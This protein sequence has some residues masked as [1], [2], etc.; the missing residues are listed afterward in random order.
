MCSSRKC[1]LGGEPLNNWG[2]RM[3]L[4][5]SKV[6]IRLV[7]ICILL[8]TIP[9]IIVGTYSTYTGSQAIQ[10]KVN[11]GNTRNLVQVQLSVEQLLYTADHIMAQFIETPVVKD[12]LKVD[13]QGENFLI[14]NTVENAINNLPTYSL[15]ASE[16]CFANVEKGWVIDNSGIYKLEDYKDREYLEEFIKKPGASFWIDEISIGI[17]TEGQDSNTGD[18]VCLVKKWPLF[19]TEP[20]CITILKIPSSQFSN[21]ISDNKAL[22]D[23][24]IIGEDGYVIAHTNKEQWGKDYN[25]IN[26]YQMATSQNADSGRFIIEIDKTDYSINYLKSSYNDWIYISKTSIADISKDS[27]TIAWF[28]LI[29]CLTVILLVYVVTLIV[30]SRFYRPIQK[31]YNMV[32]RVQDR[33]EP[34]KRQDEFM[35]I[36][37]RI[38]VL[39][40][41][42]YVLNNKLSIQSRQLKEYFILQ[43]V[44]RDMDKEVVDSRVKLYGFPKL[45]KPVC[46]LVTRIDTFEDT[47]YQNDDMDL[48]LFAIN[49]IV[50]ELLENIIVLKPI[51]VDEYQVTIIRLDVENEESESIKECAF[52]LTEN[53][54]NVINET[55]DISVSV[56]ISQPFHSYS[57]IHKAYDECLEAL[58]HQILLGY[59]AIIFYQDI[60]NIG[61]LNPVF[62]E[63]LESDL[64]DAVKTCSYKKANELLHIFISRTS[65]VEASRYEYQTSFVR[66]LTNLLQILKDSGE[67]YDITAKDGVS[68]Y[69]QLFK[70]KTAGE[71]EKWF[72]TEIIKPIIKTREE[73][74]KNQHRKIVEQV[75]NMI[76]EEF[77]TELTLE[78]CAT[79][80]NYH[81]SYIR[82][83]LK[84]ES[85][86]VFSEYLAQYRIDMAKK[87]LTETNM[88][89]S[90]IALKLRYNNSENFIRFFKKYTGMTPGRYRKTSKELP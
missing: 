36:E 84:N 10:D 19:V 88:K 27:R 47:I 74:E 7:I 44:L 59:G 14:F 69:E 23:V 34:L 6:K 3:K 72:S 62:P 42:N 90:D 13:L 51:V 28:T 26:F 29:A 48:M 32:S 12:S 83:I 53:I 63:R 15:G 1:I 56:G 40:K 67:S 55:L 61:G 38:S 73:S 54:Q 41:D 64:I 18:S 33:K 75:L 65:S 58:K 85:G 82:R 66:L 20:S 70:L 45:E 79:R 5:G 8:G 49:N 37:D 80:L 68:A 17:Q 9:A 4:F 86:I 11:E 71:I 35:L 76:H 31:L 16:I 24:M 57:E 89:I 50:G 46:V 87:W 78:L 30:T 39:L 22:G 2:N 21:L 43:L 52:L 25:L 81:P 77:H 60:K